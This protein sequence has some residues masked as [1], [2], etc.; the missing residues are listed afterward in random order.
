VTAD[1]ERMRQMRI[2]AANAQ[3]Q[4]ARSAI[5][6]AR[7]IET[8]PGGRAIS[9]NWPTSEWNDLTADWQVSTPTAFQ[10]L[11]QNLNSLRARARAE[12]RKND[13]A[14]RYVGMLRN[15]V[16][17]PD[18]FQL[19]AC[20]EDRS[21]EKDAVAN[22]AFEDHWKRWADDPRMCDVRGKSDL[23]TICR[24]LVGQL[25]TDGEFLVRMWP[26]GPMSLQLQVI[27]PAMLDVQYNDELPS[28]R[29][30]RMGIEVDDFG[31]AVA[32]WFNIKTDYAWQSGERVR[33]PAAEI[34]HAFI[35]EFP[36][37]LRGIPTLATPAYRM[38]MLDGY[39]EAA[40]VNA[41][42]GASKMGFIKSREPEGYAGEGGGGSHIDEVTPGMI[43]RLGEHD[44]WAAFNPDY[45]AGEF[46]PF[47]KQ[48]LRAVASGLEVSYPTLAN[49]L[50]GVNY[51]SLRHDALTERDIYQGLQ[52]WFAAQFLTPLYQVWL[53]RQML[54]EGG[55]PIPRRGG[56][57]R[58]ADVMRLDKYR[59]VKWIGRRWQWVD[60]L[61]EVQAN[62][63]AVALGITTR[64][65]II[66]QMGM[67]PD[68][69]LLE[70]EDER[71]RFGEVEQRG[72]SNRTPSDVQPESD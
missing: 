56:G 34:I 21:G 2:T 31:G 36:D 66:R 43:G 10:L 52:H 41:R 51:T 65:R 70:V 24:Q 54:S 3:H 59:R 58:R 17:G 42:V 39:E 33:V 1:I 40:L 45:P 14:R 7:P 22:C 60:P 32:Y 27:D 26:R 35:P 29:K 68:E 30:V 49:D 62:R 72:A 9:R 53:E 12:L 47:V 61:K 25:P 16:V 67:D 69:V 50:E 28:G 44:E 57:Y 71:S 11:H 20:F 5:P 48:M 8:R 18:G 15:G 4:V 37:Q 55:V 63:E 46:G 13:Y 23:A 64:A 19:Q 6:R 38:H